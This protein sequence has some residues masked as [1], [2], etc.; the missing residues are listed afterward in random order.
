MVGCS[1]TKVTHLVVVAE[2]P[3]DGRDGGKLILWSYAGRFT[4]SL[5]RALCVI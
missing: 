4:E 3:R 1:G 2:K 5:R